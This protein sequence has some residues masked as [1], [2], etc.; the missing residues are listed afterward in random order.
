MDRGTV[1]HGPNYGVLRCGFTVGFPVDR[2]LKIVGVF[3]PFS[4]AERRA[5]H[6]GLERR[7][8]ASDDASNL[9]D[10]SSDSVLHDAGDFFGCCEGVG[11]DIVD[12]GYLDTG[13]QIGF[14]D[15]EVDLGERFADLVAFLADGVGDLLDVCADG[16]NLR[17]EIVDQGFGLFHDGRGLLVEA[18]GEVVDPLQH[19]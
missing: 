10:R 17:T 6:Q 16:A 12:A 2:L 14:A 8:E 1:F 9:S 18:V 4:L 13:L 19:P 11:D 7:F 15:G 3:E 5:L